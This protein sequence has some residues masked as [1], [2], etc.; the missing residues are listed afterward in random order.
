MHAA[1]NS[2][3]PWLLAL[4][5]FIVVDALQVIVEVWKRPSQRKYDSDLSKVTALIPTYNGAAVI[6]QTIQ[7]LLDRGFTHEQI[8]VIDNGRTDDT[9]ALVAATGVRLY[10]TPQMGKVS[11]INFGIHRVHTPYVLL[12]DDDTRLGHARIPTG[13]LDEFDAVAF[14]VVPD[15]RDRHGP[16]GSSLFSCLQRYEYCKSMEIGRRFQDGSASIACVSGAIGLFKKTALEDQHHRHTGAFEGEDLERTLIHHLF[17][18]KVVFADETVWTVVPDNARDLFRQ[19]LFGWYPAHYHMFRN[20][21]TLLLRRGTRFR[22]RV[23]MAYNIIVVLGD[24]FRVFS[25]IMLFW[26][27]RWIE[28]AVLYLLYGLLEIVPFRVIQQKLDT[29]KRIRVF[30]VYPFYNLTHMIL[31]QLSLFV[32]IKKRFISGEMRPKSIKDRNWWLSPEE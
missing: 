26:E 3:S 7:S 17:R 28:L 6:E 25:L 11:A 9:S 15:R 19:R 14:N 12:L 1:W 30:L 22:L 8:L 32:W 31:R 13:L 21:W 24:P 16:R 10:T 5:I 2:L 23:E 4:A 27:R 18:G 20:Y 29:G